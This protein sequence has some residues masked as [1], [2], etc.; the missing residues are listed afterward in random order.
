MR[1]LACNTHTH[2]HTQ[3]RI[4][5]GQDLLR[6]VETWLQGRFTATWNTRLKPEAGLLRTCIRKH[7]RSMQR[8]RLGLETL[9]QM[10]FRTAPRLEGQLARC[11]RI[12]E[13]GVRIQDATAGRRQYQQLQRVDA[14]DNCEC[15]PAHNVDVGATNQCT[16]LDVEPSTTISANASTG[17]RSCGNSSCV[18]DGDSSWQQSSAAEGRALP[19]RGH[20][21]GLPRASSAP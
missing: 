5:Y 6:Y 19:H 1:R 11:G 15:G 13:Y 17:I 3:V 16:C 18:S 12:L 21:Q 9:H 14:I 8:T 2:T 7:R 4:V 20:V 10:H